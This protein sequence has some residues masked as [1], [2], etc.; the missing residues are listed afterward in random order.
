MTQH[1]QIVQQLE[2]RI[3]EAQ[4][5]TQVAMKAA[6]EKDVVIEK[7][8]MKASHQGEALQRGK[9]VSEITTKAKL[10]GYQSELSVKL[11]EQMH[12]YESRMRKLIGAFISTFSQFSEISAPLNEESFYNCLRRVKNEIE[13]Y[14]THESAI[15]KLIRAG[16]S[17]A[18][19]DALTQFIICHHPRLKG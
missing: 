15:R 19:E 14:R 5:A 13:K 7:L 16:E 2:I 11:D 12:E 9:E 10:I 3:A 4:E 18:I 1:Q 6:A 17:E 8:R